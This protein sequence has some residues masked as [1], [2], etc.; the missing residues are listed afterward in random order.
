[1]SV[2]CSYRVNRLR[3]IAV[4]LTNTLMERA[5][6]VSA[7]QAIAWLHEEA[8]RIEK[9]IHDGFESALAGTWWEQALEVEGG[10]PL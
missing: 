4:S 10:C 8:D 2:S 5:P 6:L 1:M 7:E 9:R 3:V